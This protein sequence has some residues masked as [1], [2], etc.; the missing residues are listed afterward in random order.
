[1]TE[2]V[3]HPL[4]DKQDVLS[5]TTSVEV[6]LPFESLIDAWRKAS[7]A[8]RAEFLRKEVWQS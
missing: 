3:I 7:R 8:E 2:H 4:Y 6:L 5:S 1:M